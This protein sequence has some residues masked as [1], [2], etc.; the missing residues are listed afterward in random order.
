MRR[1][2]WLK[3]TAGVLFGLLAFLVSR[4]ALAGAG[5]LVFTVLFGSAPDFLILLS[6]VGLASTPL[7]LAFVNATPF[8]GP[9]VLRVL[10]VIALLRLTT[11][12]STI[13][14]MDWLG[15]LGWWVT[16]WLLASLASLGLTS[17]FR[18]ARWLAW[19]GILGVSRPS[20]AEVM[21]TKPGMKNAVWE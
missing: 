16:A 15:S 19:T 4:I 20:P 17:L 18:G 13:L 7:L 2:G 8:F 1:E 6:M 10:Y 9:G 5:W 3:W 21:A 11:L 14:G 12:S